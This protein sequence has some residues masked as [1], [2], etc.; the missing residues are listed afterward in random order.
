ML[1][2]CTRLASTYRFQQRSRSQLCWCS[3]CQGRYCSVCQGRY[4]FVCQGRPVPFY[5]LPV[6]CCYQC[7]RVTM[8]LFSRYSLCLCLV[9]IFLWPIKHS[10][11]F[12]MF[13]FIKSSKRQLMALPKEFI[14]LMTLILLQKRIRDC[15]QRSKQLVSSL[16]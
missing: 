6:T 4:C 7:S 3:V 10:L 15:C 1:C 14:Q 2:N 11:Q 16:I 9:D 8:L 5:V 13:C 12:D